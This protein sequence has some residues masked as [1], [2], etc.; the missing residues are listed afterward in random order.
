MT[1]IL[2]I[3]CA[4]LIIIALTSLTR[5]LSKF[6]TK[7]KLYPNRIILFDDHYHTLSSRY[8]FDFEYLGEKFR[9]RKTIFGE[10][11]DKLALEINGGSAGANNVYISIYG[12]AMDKGFNIH[13]QM[14]GG[15]K[16]VS[17]AT[18][19]AL[20]Y[21]EL[22]SYVENLVRPLIDRCNE[23]IQNYIKIS[24]LNLSQIKSAEDV[25]KQMTGAL[26][27][28]SPNRLIRESAQKLYH[29]E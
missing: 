6:S 29:K 20:N 1:T 12:N 14:N 13:I 17:N 10:D 16:D 9:Y 2:I 5:F 8:Q 24:S 3:G 7:K 26:G 11:N 21:K 25:K 18:Y 4:V 19:H 23:E 22:P 28:T 15:T 27:L